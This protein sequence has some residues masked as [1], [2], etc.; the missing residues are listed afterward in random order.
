MPKP[1]AGDTFDTDTGPTSRTERECAADALYLLI[2]AGHIRPD[3]KMADLCRTVGV[4]LADIAAA[5]ARWQHHDRLKPRPSMRAAPDPATIAAPADWRPKPG[6][7]GNA[8]SIPSHVRRTNPAPGLRRCPKCK[9]TLPVTEFDRKSAKSN[10]LR[11]FCRPCDK[12]YQRE[13]YLTVRKALAVGQAV[14]MF[15]VIDGDGVIGMPCTECL[16]QIVVGERVTL[17]AAPRHA[18]CD[19]PVAV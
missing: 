12:T 19:E 14:A 16:R 18:H 7:T 5:G 3:V 4:T 8:Q 11:A 1:H 13:R 2:V 17:E 10:T 9:E 15:R 6:G